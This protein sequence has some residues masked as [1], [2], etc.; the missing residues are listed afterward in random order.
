MMKHEST[1]KAIFEHF[2]EDWMSDDDK[3]MMNNAVL[4]VTGETLESL[5]EKIEVGVQNGYS[6]ECQM[7][8]IREFV[9]LHQIKRND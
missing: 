7:V 6:V 1:I 2:H 3:L 5:D 8:I 4:S 9:I